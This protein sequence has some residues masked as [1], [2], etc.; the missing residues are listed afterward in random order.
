MSSQSPGSAL[1]RWGLVGAVLL[2]V[3]GAF[4]WAAG[5]LAP[6]LLTAERFI[7]AFER[8]NGTP[9]PAGFRRNHAKGVCAAGF[10]DGNG[11]GV[12]ISKAV[13]FEA[14]RVPVIARFALAG[15]HPLAADAADTVRSLA[16]LFSMPDGEEWRSGMNDIPVFPVESA[17]GFYDQ[18]VASAPD[19]K[20]GKP[21]PAKMAAFLAKHPESARAI[22]LIQHRSVS[23]GFDDDTYNGLN[24]FRFVNAAGVSVPVRWSLAAAQAAEAAATDRAD[25]ESA[26]PLF[27]R[28][29]ARVHRGPLRWR[30]VATLGQA[31]D[32]TNDATTPWPEGRPKVELGTLTIDRIESEDEGPCRDVN[33]DPLVLPAGIEP[34]D[35]PLLSAR[36]AAYAESFRRRVGETKAPS[37][38]TPAETRR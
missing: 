9:P 4:A 37:A 13:V 17:E 8:V 22:G 15:G 36:S 3:V 12:A 24:A 29:I 18:L 31:G 14:G 25:A 28:L 35:D 20:T 7:D 1:P 2:G 16:V 6:D 33:Y 5:W 19:P 23:S 26:N 10:F 27:D 34:S 30:L 21:D 11:Q 32:P 38:V